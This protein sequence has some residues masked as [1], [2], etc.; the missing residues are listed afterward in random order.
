M[1]YLLNQYD[2][3]FFVS[4]KC[5]TII[6]YGSSGSE[7]INMCNCLNGNP[8]LGRVFSPQFFLLPHWPSGKP[9]ASR[10]EGPGFESRLRRDFFG[11]ESYR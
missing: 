7:L 4:V 2:F 5:F 6:K 11:V 9:S 3:C 8:A 10:A 1:L